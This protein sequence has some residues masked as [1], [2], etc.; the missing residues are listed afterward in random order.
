MSEF[1]GQPDDPGALA[2]AN[3]LDMQWPPPEWGGMFS[4]PAPS[5]APTPAPDDPSALQP[6]LGIPQQSLDAMPPPPDQPIA[7]A[8]TGADPHAGVGQL[9]DVHTEAAAP[10]MGE[11]QPEVG[12]PGYLE[13]V[14]ATGGRPPLPGA[15]A[16][17]NADPSLVAPEI[18]AQLPSLHDNAV[19]QA[20]ENQSE[21][22]TTHP[23]DEARDRA[24]DDKLARD[25][26]RAEQTRL[27]DENDRRQLAE[28]AAHVAAMAKTQQDMQVIA[29]T[30]IDPDQH[31]GIGQSILNVVALTLGGAVSKYTGGR[32][33]ALEQ[34][35]KAI[36][37]NID[38]QKANLANRWKGAQ[39]GAQ[40]EADSFKEQ[41]AFRVGVYN[42]A[43]QKIQTK[44]QDF[45]PQGQQNRE[46]ADQYRKILSDRDMATASAA[47]KMFDNNFKTLVPL[48]QKQQ[49]ID[50]TKREHDLTYAEKMAAMAAKAAKG[51]PAAS[52]AN[53]NQLVAGLPPKDRERAVFA[54]D[55][56][57]FRLAVDHETA[58]KQREEIGSGRA[59][60]GAADSVIADL[61]NDTDLMTKIKAKAGLNPQELAVLKSKLSLLKPMIAKV[62][63]G[64]GRIP[65]AELHAVDAAT[66]DPSG[67]TSETLAQIKAMRDATVNDLSDKFDPEYPGFI[68]KGSFG[69]APEIKDAPN[70]NTISGPLLEAPVKGDKGY[71]RFDLGNFDQSLKQVFNEYKQNE[72]LGGSK[73]LAS[74]YDTIAEKQQA[75]IDQ[76]SGDID[77]LNKKAKRTP[78]ENA[79][80]HNDT[81]ALADRRQA[82]LA[83]D[84]AKKHNLEY[85]R[86]QAAKA[87]SKTAVEK[88]LFYTGTGGR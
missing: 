4:S 43:L 71:A 81:L 24:R 59:A 62:A 38:A 11:P 53:E 58:V 2:P 87:K 78:E 34:L 67:F 69:H 6:G 18:S 80:L 74:H 61:S 3:P 16:G 1:D 44:M 7:D 36:D 66:D 70:V 33:L 63:A 21:F 9:A 15:A 68:G 5:P 14:N 17:V 60:I 45:N 75:A 10:P 51:G 31:L 73:D 47:Q 72:G 35:N 20:N 12:A 84:D 39:E 32:N 27:S 29:N 48:D 86:E 49:E 13:Q 88:Q 65:L 79:Q 46:L 52:T 54:P 77:K 19:D 42:A 41:T 26:F 57:S 8:T 30:K 28:H 76:I 85:E 56:K 23:L 83:I 25:Q 82:I 22:Y 64:T 55:G 50:E 40:A 37:A